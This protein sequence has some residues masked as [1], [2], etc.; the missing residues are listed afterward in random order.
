MNHIEFQTSVDRHV[1]ITTADND[2]DQNVIKPL[3]T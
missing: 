3:N 1:A 2:Q